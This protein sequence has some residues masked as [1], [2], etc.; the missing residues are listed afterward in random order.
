[1]K[2]EKN[3]FSFLI[4][5]N[6][7]V[8]KFLHHRKPITSV[9]WSPHDSTVFMASGED[10]QTTIWDLALEAEEPNYSNG[11]DEDGVMEEDDEGGKKIKKND[12]VEQLPPQLLFIHMGL[13][14]KY[15]YSNYFKQIKY[16][17]DI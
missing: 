6:Q 3:I 4:Q 5:Y 13:K 17:M 7:P 14:G 12:G 2:T 11:D 8:A 10:D 1:M 15:K 16:L 9:E